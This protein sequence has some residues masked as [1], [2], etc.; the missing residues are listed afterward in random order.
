MPHAVHRLEH[1]ADL[2]NGHL[3]ITDGA[4]H[5]FGQTQLFRLLGSRPAQGNLKLCHTPRE[6]HDATKESLGQANRPHGPAPEG[7]TRNTP[8][9]LPNELP[10]RTT[11]PIELTSHDQ[12]IS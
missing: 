7:R 3:P 1:R 2:F 6:N 4:G 11:S 12:G 5:Q 9:P 8:L 10:I